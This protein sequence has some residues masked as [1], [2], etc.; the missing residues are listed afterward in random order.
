MHRLYVRHGAHGDAHHGARFVPVGW[1]CPD[2]HQI[3][4]DLNMVG[5]LFFK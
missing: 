4:T 1:M 3:E 5:A 2:C